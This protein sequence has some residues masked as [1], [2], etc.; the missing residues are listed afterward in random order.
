MDGHGAAG[1]AG[2]QGLPKTHLGGLLDRSLEPSKRR[3]GERDEKKK[4][5]ERD[6]RL[7]ATPGVMARL[8]NRWEFDVV[9]VGGMRQTVG[10]RFGTLAQMRRGV[11]GCGCDLRARGGWKSKKEEVK[12]AK[13][14]LSGWPVANCPELPPRLAGWP[15][16]RPPP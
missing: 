1:R 13:C 15:L 8:F 2:E 5:N 14:L 12:E 10:G 11:A 7:R 4:C 16:L 9:D 3:E 6:G